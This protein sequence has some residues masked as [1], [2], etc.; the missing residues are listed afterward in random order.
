MRLKEEE[1]GPYI[2]NKNK[3][4]PTSNRC[5][6]HIWKKNNTCLVYHVDQ[7]FDKSRPVKIQHDTINRHD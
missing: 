2:G 4:N 6:I 1:G 5:G 7:I 3:E